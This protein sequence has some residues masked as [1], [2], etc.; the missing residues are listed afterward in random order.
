[1]LVTLVQAMVQVKKVRELARPLHLK[2]SGRKQ[3][4]NTQL[5]KKNDHA[6][7]Q[8]RND[9]LSKNLR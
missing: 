2:Q 4:A 1:M 8:N 5:L 3:N 6:T 7:K 9:I